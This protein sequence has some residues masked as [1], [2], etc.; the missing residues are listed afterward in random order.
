[1]GFFP[2]LFSNNVHI[3]V[4]YHI[5]VNWFTTISAINFLIVL[6]STSIFDEL[7][8]KVIVAFGEPSVIIIASNMS[9][10]MT[11]TSSIPTLG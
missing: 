4:Y 1:M 3:I 2:G 6:S 9:S 7:G 10:L 8:V 5:C 11:E